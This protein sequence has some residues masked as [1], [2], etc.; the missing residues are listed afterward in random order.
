MSIKI[1]ATAGALAGATIAVINNK[2]NV[3]RGTEYILQMGADFCKQRL[4]KAHEMN[5][6]FSQ[7]DGIYGLYGSEGS[8]KDSTGGNSSDALGSD[9]DEA[10]TPDSS[11]MS[12]ASDEEIDMISLD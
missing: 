2:E 1:A 9:R 5:I 8:W 10:T 3:L 12:D 4:E 11:D 6:N 7:S